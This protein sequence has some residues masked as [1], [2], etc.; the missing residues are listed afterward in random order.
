MERKREKGRDESREGVGRKTEKVTRK[1][2]NTHGPCRHTPSCCYR[3]LL[4]Q[5]TGHFPLHYYI[6]WGQ[7]QA[8]HHRYYQQGPSTH[9]WIC[10]NGKKGGERH[11][12]VVKTTAGTHRSIHN[13]TIHNK[14]PHF[15]RSSAQ[16]TPPLSV[17]CV[18]SEP[19]SPAIALQ[20]FALLSYFTDLTD[21]YRPQNSSNR[22][23]PFSHPPSVGCQQ[24]QIV[25]IYPGHSS[26]NYPHVAGG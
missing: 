14:H 21:N 18:L 22:N 3:Q 20:L 6:H 23:I 15:S 2:V 25:L 12:A 19:L 13:I 24:S 16:H 17:P 8:H 10:L 11:L 26:S 1:E 9:D 5:L 4:H 7:G